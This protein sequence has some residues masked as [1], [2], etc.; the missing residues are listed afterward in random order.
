MVIFTDA[1]LSE[2]PALSRMISETTLKASRVVPITLTVPFKFW[3]YG[4]LVMVA[5][6][7]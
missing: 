1:S 2:R 3:E 5:V 6:K 7:R 4:R